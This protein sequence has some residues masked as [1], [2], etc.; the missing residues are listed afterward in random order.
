VTESDTV[1]KALS[2]LEVIDTNASAIVQ[3]IGRESVDV[4]TFLANH[5][6]AG[7][8]QSSPVFQFVF[9]SFYRLDSAG[10]PPELKSRYFELLEDARGQSVIDL[11]RIV[12]DLYAFPNLKGQHS[13]QFSFATK[14]A[15]TANPH[16]PLYDGEVASVFQFHPPGNWLSFEKRL[17]RY[18]DFY[19]KLRELYADVL[20]QNLLQTPRRLF[21]ASYDAPPE[22]VPEMKVLDFIFWSA[23]KLGLVVYQ[24]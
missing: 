22:R 7:S 17:Q 23:G 4:Y 5:F 16:Y 10:L 6:K 14:L 21:R 18:L 15:H 24:L 12:T 8:V 3:A 11:R 13:L 20:E 1:R 2:A 9:R 19:G